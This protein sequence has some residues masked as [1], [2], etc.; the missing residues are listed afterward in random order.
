MRTPRSILVKTC[1][2]PAPGGRPGGRR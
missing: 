1:C 2:R